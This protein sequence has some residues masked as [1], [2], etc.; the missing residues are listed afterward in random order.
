MSFVHYSCYVCNGLKKV[1]IG[2]NIDNFQEGIEYC[3][4]CNGKGYLNAKYVP[5][6]DEFYDK[7]WKRMMIDPDKNDVDKF[8]EDN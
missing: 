2:R 8:K 7:Y 6:T 1:A 3:P 4:N 5:F